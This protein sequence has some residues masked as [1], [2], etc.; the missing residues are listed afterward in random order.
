MFNLCKIKKLFCDKQGSILLYVMVYGALS[1]AF[2]VIGIASYTT[3]EFKATV[4]RE[5]REKAFQIA[6]AGIEYYKWHLAKD[7]YDYQD[8]KGVPGPYEHPYKDKE[9]NVIGYFSLNITPPTNESNVITIDSTGWLTIQPQSRRTIRAKIS[10]TALSDYAFVSNTDIWIGNNTV[11][12]GKLHSNSGIRFDGIGDAPITSAV[13]TYVCKPSH[14]E[15]CQNQTK[16]GVWGQGGPQSYWNYPVPAEDFS[17]ATAAI[18]QIKTEAQNGGLYIPASGKQGWRLRFISNGTVGVSKVN[19][20]DCYKGDDIDGTKN[21]W[22]CVDIKNTDEE[23]VYSL[24]SNGYIYVDDTTWVDGTVRGK[25]TVG[26]GSDKSIIINGSLLY[27]LKD[28]S[29]RLG[30]ITDKDVIVPRNSPDNLE[31]NGALHTARGA[32]KRYYY[33]G[34]T[35]DNLTIYGSIISGG[36]W[37]WSWISSGG[38]VV[39]GYENVVSTYDVN[40]TNNPPVGF[41]RGRSYRLVS[42]EVVR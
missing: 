28:G 32:A 25:V 31:I 27:T 15:G 34:N 21:V 12:H 26:I 39:S 29:D 14:G 7:S 35:K 40:L 23:T 10:F 2:I 22:F 20:T 5:N 37:T 17:G 24:P 38:A 13:D 4:Y 3:S 8:G 33:S 42:W 16:P 11:I 18:A 1:F 19:S 6:E 30:L 9:G 41:P 36:A